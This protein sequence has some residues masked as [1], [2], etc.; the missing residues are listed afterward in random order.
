MPHSTNA[1]AYEHYLRGRHHLWRRDTAEG[2][3]KAREHFRRAIDLDDSYAHA[4]SGLADTYTML[5]SAG[6]LPM[7]QAYPFARA[8]ALKALALNGRL[9]EAHTSLAFILADY[10]GD[11]DTADRHFRSALELNPNYETAVRTYAGYL[12]WW[13]RDKEALEFA[14]WARLDPVAERTAEPAWPTTSP[15]ATTTPSSSFERRR[16]RSE[17]QRGPR[18]WDGHMSPGSP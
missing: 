10:D 18:R 2:F 8:A 17:L 7:R 12:A 15:V 13:G 4:Y 6:F 11:W 1:E 3:E 9:A 16:S 14:R 5:G